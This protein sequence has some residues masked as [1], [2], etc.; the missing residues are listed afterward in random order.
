MAALLVASLAVP[1]GCCARLQV[2]HAPNRGTFGWP[3]ANILG[4]YRWTKDGGYRCLDC[5]AGSVSLR[6]TNQEFMGSTRWTFVTH[7]HQYPVYA[8]AA[9]FCPSGVESWNYWKGNAFVEGD[10][11]L[12]CLPATDACC[13]RLRLAEAPEDGVVG[14]PPAKIVSYYRW[15]AGAYECEDCEPDA[16]V[17]LE[18]VT[19][20]FM[21]GG[22]HWTFVTH[23]NQYPVFAEGRVTCPSSSATWKWWVPKQGYA[24]RHLRLECDGPAAAPTHFGTPAHLGEAAGEAAGELLGAEER[25]PGDLVARLSQR[26]GQHGAAV[27]AG[28]G[29]P[30][31]LGI[32]AVC[33]CCLAL[34]GGAHFFSKY[35]AA[36][37]AAE[38]PRRKRR[39]SRRSDGGSA[40]DGNYR[41]PHR[42]ERAKGRPGGS[43]RGSAGPARTGTCRRPASSTTSN[44]FESDLERARRDNLSSSDE[45]T[46][47]PYRGG[48]VPRGMRNV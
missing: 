37:A 40:R 21:G 18:P 7:E 27:V 42:S 22:T 2:L 47:V 23:H 14:S 17:S 8:A 1:D 26:A 25:P 41:T 19:E 43:W 31:L 30:T 35:R 45:A 12:R 24:L 28:V 20:P 16:P 5:D 34:C 10:I 33:C 32:N 3:T 44:Q 11:M 9:S 15:S 36:L 48:D 46:D 38:R 13:E 29:V 4:T 39:E 6:P